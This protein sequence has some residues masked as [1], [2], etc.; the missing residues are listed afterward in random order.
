MPIFLIYAKI[1]EKKISMAREKVQRELTL[2]LQSKYFGPKDIEPA[3]T[4]V[5]LHEE[6]EAIQL[7]SIENMYQEDAAKKM[8]VSRATFS[9]IIKNA[10]RKVAMALINGYNI[11]IHE[12]K[13]DFSVAV[14]SSSKTELTDINLYSEYIFIFHIQDYKLTSQMLIKNPAFDKE[15]KPSQL[16]PKLFQEQEV[17][18]FITDKLGVTLKNAL[19]AKGIYPII[20]DNNTISIDKV[21][22]IFK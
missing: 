17:N 4:I 6:I 18:Y 21:V 5:L 15:K 1:R 10:R 22:D 14:C 11:K 19:I 16:F 3:E 7:M 12:V 8:N 2:T 13:N 9:R 20:K